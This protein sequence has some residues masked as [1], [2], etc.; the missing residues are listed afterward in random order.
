VR[1]PKEWHEELQK[2][3]KQTGRSYRTILGIALKKLDED[4]TLVYRHGY[5]EGAKDGFADGHK[6]GYQ[7]AQEDMRCSRQ[8]A[9]DEAYA[10]GAKEWTITIPCAACSTPVIIKPNSEEHKTIIYYA[11][12]YFFKH[13]QCFFSRR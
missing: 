5:S 2:Y 10:K 12:S 4:H 9:I 6:A 8:P 11:K 3:R 1:I 7:Q 13:T